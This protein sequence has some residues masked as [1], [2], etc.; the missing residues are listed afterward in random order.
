M[1]HLHAQPSGCVRSMHDW[2]ADLRTESAHLV[3]RVHIASAIFSV[4]GAYISVAH[5]EL[6]R[7]INMH[8]SST[9]VRDAIMF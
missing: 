4:V 6:R 5:S 1:P 7:G 2:I 3:N 8:V 9:C